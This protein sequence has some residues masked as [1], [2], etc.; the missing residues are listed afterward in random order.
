[1]DFLKNKHLILAMFVAPLLAVFAYFA[2]DQ[3]VSE[4][5]HTAVAG[6][7]YKL[8]AKSNCRYKSGLCTLENGDVEVNLRVEI[9][10]NS[11]ATVFL[12]SVLPL[13]NALVSFVDDPGYE[14]VSPEPTPMLAS[15]EQADV[16]SA[17]F[18]KVPSDNSILR[19]A[20]SISD[21]LYYAETTTIFIEY[22]TS[23]S[24]DNFSN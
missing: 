16:W 14:T 11:R 9:I 2:V 17:S 24:R 20:L 23:F 15:L 3:V 10:D 22:E 19:L 4:E 6:S 12:S 21:T 5:P 7:S 1:M 8:A 18:D 13:Q